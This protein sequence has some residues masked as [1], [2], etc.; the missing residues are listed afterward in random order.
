MKNE[1]WVNTEIAEG[2]LRGRMEEEIFVFRGI[3]YAAPPL[4]P[5]RW[6][7][8]QPVAPW[9]DVRDASRWG[10]ASWQNRA[11]CIAYGGGDP[12][13]PDEDC[14]YLNVWTPDIQPQEKLP[15]MVWIHGGGY[16]LGSGSLAPYHG[17]ALAARGVVMVTLNY[18]LGHLG[19]FAH[20]ALDDEYAPGEAINNFALLDQIAAL[21]WVQ[22][23]IHAFGGDRHNVTIAGESCG[24]HSV[25]ALYTS[26]LALG[27]FHKG[28]VQSV[29]GL[30]D[31]PR[32]AALKNGE[33]VARQLNLA[34]AS[35]EQLR[36]LPADAFCALGRELG[37]GP[38]AIAGDRVLPQSPLQVFSAAR[39]H[40][41]PL[42]IGSNSDEA[43]VLE[44]FGLD[45][46]NALAQMREKHKPGF[47]LVRLLYPA[48]DDRQL[49]RQVVRDLVFTT[50]GYVV[51]Q[52]QHRAG[53]PCW[54]YYFDYVSER[55]RDLYCYGVWHGNEIPYVL[56][57][58][59]NMTP[60]DSERPYSAGDHQFAWRASEYWLRFVRE[61]NP[62][63]QYIE[64]EVRW[65]SWHP[66]RDRTLRFGVDGAAD[67]ILEKRFMRRRMQ[68]FRLLMRHLVRLN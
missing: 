10:K 9:G 6:R 43:S 65:P 1:Q 3:P 22:R 21:Q 5:L 29:Y 19:F 2:T 13:Q 48:L 26:P 25:L 37:N 34:N 32:S 8:P 59:K 15:V 52:A 11:E 17:A 61:V 35:A 27:L 50:M 63:S 54:R 49:G 14:L 55:A 18:R 51:A 64:G 46:G 66:R 39:Q 57:T 4:G 58:L 67:M 68:L 42:M 40:R 47:Y 16:R 62:G 38:V 60:A 20:P 56:D 45:T 30:P 44:H 41:Y 7:A 31:K 33:V 12:G 24:G 53:A 36:A 28:I 23:N